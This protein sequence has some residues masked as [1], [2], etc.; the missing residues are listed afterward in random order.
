M[1]VAATENSDAAHPAIVIE[2]DMPAEG[3]GPSTYPVS[4]SIYG[5]H[6][7]RVPR[8]GDLPQGV[9]LNRTG[10]G[11]FRS[12]RLG[13]DTRVS[14]PMGSMSLAVGIDS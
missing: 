1:D 9:D 11:C 6:E 4:L 3:M 12:Y 13:S 8:P 5:Q 14:P 7:D 10:R 2:A